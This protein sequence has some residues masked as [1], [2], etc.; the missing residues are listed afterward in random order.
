MAGLPSA[1]Q[2]SQSRFVELAAVGDCT[3]HSGPPHRMVE[4]RP[5]PWIGSLLVLGGVQH[6]FKYL[7]ITLEMP[8]VQQEILFHRVHLQSI[9]GQVSALRAPEMGGIF[10]SWQERVLAFQTL[11][12]SRPILENRRRMQ[13]ARESLRCKQAGAPRDATN[14]TRASRQS[15]RPIPPK[16]CP[17]IRLVMRRCFG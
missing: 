16:S 6:A 9:L 2:A 1:Q 11:L 3:Q 15:P 7:G 14:I 13:A 4:Q 17:H 5:G 10:A 12:D 8:Q